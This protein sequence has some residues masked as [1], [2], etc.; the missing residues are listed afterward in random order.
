[1]IARAM[2][3]E[4]TSVTEAEVKMIIKLIDST[5]IVVSVCIRPIVNAFVKFKN[6]Y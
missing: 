1:M 5:A 2:K 4:I 3:F 6:F